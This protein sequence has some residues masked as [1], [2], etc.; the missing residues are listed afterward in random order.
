MFLF[1]CATILTIR[2]IYIRSPNNM[3]MDYTSFNTD[4][5]V[6]NI[7]LSHR[8]LDNMGSLL[9]QTLQIMDEV[10]RYLESL[11]LEVRTG[12]AESTITLPSAPASGVLDEG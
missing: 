3:R 6:E 8:A 1:L 9:D 7:L 4:D 11:K 10:K 12:L 5:A 2:L